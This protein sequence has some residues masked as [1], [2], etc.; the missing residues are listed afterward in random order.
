VTQ[1]ETSKIRL[2]LSPQAEKYARRDAPVEAR[3]MAARGALPLEPVELATVL[4]ALLHD[5]DTEVKTRAAESL[6]DLPEAVAFTVLSGPTHPALLSHLA[7]VHSDSESHCEKVALNAAT[8]NTTLA[9][10]ATLPQRRLIDIISNNQERLMQSEEIVEALGANPLTGRAVI[11][12][13]LTFLGIDDSDEGDADDMQGADD[14]SSEAAAA[15]VLA[16]LGEDM[17]DVAYHLSTEDDIDDEEV[18]NNLFSAIQKMS[19][20]QKIK[21]ARVG[22]KEARMLLIRDRNKIVSTSVI[23][24]PKITETEVVTIAKS[25]NVS[26]EIL[27]LIS[28]NRDW[29]K[30]YQIKSALATN[31]KTPQ[32]VAIKFLNYLP[33][34]DLRTIMKSKDVPSAISAHARRILQKKGKV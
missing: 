16:L 30:S 18:T 34:R 32:P 15:A 1:V 19:V 26:D 28:N 22:G 8:D 7:H 17:A 29:T 23:Q 27:R 25:R 20:M 12:R 9:F 33:E 2:T 6:R 31:P 10:L 14:I 13:I 21:L 24:S 4:F 5:P 3:R 11:E